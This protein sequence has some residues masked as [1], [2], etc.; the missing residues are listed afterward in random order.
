MY[1]QPVQGHS[2]TGSGLTMVPMMAG[3][4]TA[5]I[6]VGQLVTRYGRYRVF[7][8]AGMATAT[9]GLALLST[10]GPGTTRGVLVT[11]LVVLGLGLGMVTQVLVV[12]AQNAASYENLGA[13]TSGATMFRLIGG[14]VGTAVLGTVF[15]GRVQSSVDPLVVSAAIGHVFALAAMVAA[16]GFA[17]TWLVP[18]RPL[19]ETVAAASAGVGREA[20][21]AFAMAPTGDRSL[22][23]LRGLAILADRDVQRAYIEGIVARAGVGLS[24]IAAWLLLRIEEQ[25]G[26]DPRTLAR[27]VGIAADRV[28][29][30]LV[31]LVERGLVQP[32][33]TGSVSSWRRCCGVSPATWSRRAGAGRPRNP[34]RR[35]ARVETPARAALTL[36]RLDQILEAVV[37]DRGALLH[38][39]ADHR[40]PRLARIVLGGDGEPRLAAF[41]REQLG[42]QR[43]AVRERLED[44]GVDQPSRP[45]DL[46][47]LAVEGRVVAFR[48]AAD[49]APCAA[50]AQID[51]AD[52]HR[53]A[54]VEAA[55]PAA[56]VLGLRHRLPHQIARRVEQPRQRDL[57]VGG[58]GALERAAMS[59]AWRG[60]H[61]SSPWPA[62]AAGSCPVDR[63]APPRRAGTVRPTRTPP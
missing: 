62:A 9:L 36:Q 28:A 61:A 16:I 27:R 22:E 60:A 58:G 31:E 43:A 37:A 13:A 14:S 7:P 12:A 3:T 4:L 8:I 17:F 15:A 46:E 19:R 40:V 30:G 49:E 44:L 29:V 38:P 5:S 24:A 10:I 33:G 26:T 39:G 1:L 32:R 56:D 35:Q 59:G 34:R 52:R 20:G 57:G 51:L 25:P 55:P 47:V 23:L 50:D 41:R 48:A 2:P 18:E 6:T 11:E 54:F 45:I 21:N 63:G 53:I 42:H